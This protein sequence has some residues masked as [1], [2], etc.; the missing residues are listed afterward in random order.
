[1]FSFL[2]TADTTMPPNTGYKPH[3]FS[4]CL[5]DVRFIYLEDVI[6]TLKTDTL[7]VLFYSPSECVNAVKQMGGGASLC[8]LSTLVLSLFGLCMTA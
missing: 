6:L 3:C 2:W 7:H 1:M 5:L 8:K 4:P